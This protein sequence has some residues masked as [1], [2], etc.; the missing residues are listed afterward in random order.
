[1]C[2]CWKSFEAHDR[3]CLHFLEDI[4]GRDMDNKGDSGETEVRKK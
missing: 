3:K 2:R 4:V 1:M